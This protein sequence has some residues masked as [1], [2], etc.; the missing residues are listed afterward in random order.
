MASALAKEKISDAAVKKATGCTWERWYKA[1]DQFG[2]RK[3]DHKGIVA[4]AG[5]L[6]PRMNGWWQ[7]MVTVSYEQ[8]R[9][10]RQKHEKP[11]GFEVSASKTVAVP[12][13]KLYRAWTDA[14]LR[15]RWLGAAR[16]TVSKATPNRSMRIRWGDGSSRVNV[17]FY[18][19]GAA[20]SQV[21]V[22]HGHLPSAAAGKKTQA[23]WKARLEKLP[24]TLGAAAK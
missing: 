12:L 6:S 18:A 1:L 3:L 14:R 22:Q 8:A 11:E 5:K 24:A 17:M 13:V 21:A 7:Q 16:F 10:L 20:K 15:R 2:A 4:L 19:K 23:F 9:G